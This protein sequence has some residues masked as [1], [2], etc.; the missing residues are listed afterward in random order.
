MK[1]RVIAALAMALLPA[2]AFA[3]D[4]VVLINQSTVMSAGGFPYTITQPGSYRLSGNLTVA[5]ANTNAIDI[6]AN[7]VTIDLNGF[8]IIGPVVCTGE[9]I[10]LKCSPNG[11]GAGVHAGVA[12][13]GITVFNG[14]VTRMGYF[15]INLYSHSSS[16]E[17]V[18]ADFNG[19]GGIYVTDATVSGCTAN[20]NGRSGIEVNSSTVSGNTA[21]HN[22]NYGIVVG[23][24]PSA[25]V[26]NTATGNG[27]LNLLVPLASSC[28]VVSNAA[29]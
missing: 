29:Q 23:D 2:C 17:R 8:S 15:G 3:V 18:H 6:F 25:I 14:S 9:G 10:N 27:A 5:D 28:A 11:I 7:N 21:N 24:C 12:S 19:T 13:W 26:G 22:F 1:K 20:F 16:V 4:G